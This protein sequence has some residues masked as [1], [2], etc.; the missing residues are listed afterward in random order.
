MRSTGAAAGG[1]L[2]GQLLKHD[3]FVA[4]PEPAQLDRPGMPARLNRWHA[5]TLA[6]LLALPLLAGLTLLHVFGRSLPWQGLGLLAVVG[7]VAYLVGRRSEAPSIAPSIF[8][9]WGFLVAAGLSLLAVLGGISANGAKRWVGVEGVFVLRSG[10]WLNVL[11][12]IALDRWLGQCPHPGRGQIAC[13]ALAVLLTVASLAAMPDAYS[14]ILFAGIVLAVGLGASAPVVKR[15]FV[16]LGGA[17][18]LA[19]A[20]I[21]LSSFRRDRL[22]AALNDAWL[23]PAADPIG[24]GFIALANQKAH[25]VGGLWGVDI[26]T[27]QTLGVT[28]PANMDWYA[29]S[30]VALGQGQVIALTASLAVLLLAA[31][32]LRA[33]WSLPTSQRRIPLIL[34]GVFAFNS[35]CAVLAPWGVLP[36]V[37]HYGVPFLAINDA[38]VL[39]VA[40]VGWWLAQLKQGHTVSP[41]RIES[42]TEPQT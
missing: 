19:P 6:F 38:T 17:M 36:F 18:L 24:R 10:L 34:G 42:L 22:I 15:V 9:R 5:G 23:D 39:G 11:W 21:L 2:S 3:L 20:L 30:W 37:G 41:G 32:L 31:I 29:P 40:L 12:L 28:L 25:V 14:L 27:S 7:I 1:W 13:V 4:H 26:G 8:V 33:A 35:A 16:G